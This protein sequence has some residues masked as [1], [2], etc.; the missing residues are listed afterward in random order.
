MGGRLLNFNLLKAKNMIRNS[1]LS[2][3]NL[4]FFK[5]YKVSIDGAESTLLKKLYIHMQTLRSYENAIRDRYHPADKMRCPLHLCIGQEAAPA[6]VRMLHNEG[7]YIFSHHR[8]HGYY[9]SST[10]EMKHLIAELYGKETGAS[11]GLAGSQDISNSDMKFYS[12]AILAGSIGIAVGVALGLKQQGSSNKVIVG[13]GE[14]CTEEGAFWEAINYAAL[15]KLPIIFICENNKYATYSAQLKRQ[16][17]DNIAEKVEAFGVKANKI[18]GNDALA[19][20]NT[21]LDQNNENKNQLEPFFLETYTYRLNSH[22][23]PEDDSYNNYRT[24][25]EIEFWKTLCPITLLENEM[26]NK[27]II[28][29]I[30]INQINIK[31]DSDVNKDFEFAEDSSFPI[32]KDGWDELNCNRSR[33]IVGFDRLP[34]KI[35][36]EVGQHEAKLINY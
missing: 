22:V 33:N 25:Q 10:S 14:A 23:G 28:D 20:Y 32:I 31:I 24:P 36:F 30:W 12:G 16:P 8:S 6:A 13:F 27:K 2:H 26:L 3:E 21:L 1:K 5:G 7:D 15:E 19:I 18:F 17:K 9:Y 29:S 11:G 34:S 35:D 4:D